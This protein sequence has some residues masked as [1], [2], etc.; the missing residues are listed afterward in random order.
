M[1]EILFEKGRWVEKATAKPHQGCDKPASA[2]LVVEDPEKT[3]TWHLPVKGCDG[4]PDHRLMGAAWAALH[5]GYRGNKYQGPGKQQAI[6]KLRSLYE[7]EGMD[8]PD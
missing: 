8:L 2:F 1:K 6:S 7:R 3:S 4:K 5:G